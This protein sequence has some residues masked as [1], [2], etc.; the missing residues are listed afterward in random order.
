MPP[1]LQTIEEVART[2]AKVPE[3]MLAISIFAASVFHSAFR[4]K[5]LAGKSGD[6]YVV[7]TELPTAGVRALNGEFT[8]SRGSSD[9]HS[10]RLRVYGVQTSEDHLLA[11]MG[12]GDRAS[13]IKK[14]ALAVQKLVESE[15]IY[16]DPDLPG[17]QYHLKGLLHH[18][19]TSGYPQWTDI[20]AG[21][22]SGG[23]ALSRSLV[24]DGMSRCR[25]ENSGCTHIICGEI[26]K[27]KLLAD[28]EATVE[29]RDVTS[30]GRTN[31]IP[32]YN[33]AQVVPL[34][35][36]AD[37]QWLLDFNEAAATGPATATSIYFVAHDETGFYPAQNGIVKHLALAKTGSQNI[38]RQE[39][40]FLTTRNHPLSVV[41]IKHIG[42][43]PMVP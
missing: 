20:S 25:S 40:L 42:N 6:D 34:Q 13:A 39:G 4:W 1:T 23:A 35:Q 19:R 15:A 22:D 43:K 32:F 37:F 30:F 26:Q 16:S 5:N 7:T 17:Q 27:N 41:R 8:T 29:Y 31:K 11:E 3:Q 38:D 9:P 36:D 33:G 2:E 21:S 18:A 28:A 12:L 14:G 24:R 10:N